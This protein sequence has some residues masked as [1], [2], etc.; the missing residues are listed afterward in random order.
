M[1]ELKY[2]LIKEYGDLGMKNVRGI[3]CTMK[4]VRER[5]NHFKPNWAIRMFN[6]EGQYTKGQTL[7]TEQLLALKKL[8]ETIDPEAEDVQ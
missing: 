8:L 5:W 3:S 6:P 7:T 2:E 1:S 4:L